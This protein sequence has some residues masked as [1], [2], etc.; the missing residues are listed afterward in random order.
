MENY[1]L[2]RDHETEK[3]DPVSNCSPVSMGPSGHHLTHHHE[4]IRTSTHIRLS[5][6]RH[7]KSI[8]YERI[9][10]KM[11]PSRVGLSD[12]VGEDDTIATSH[13]N[14][15][16]SL[17]TASW[18]WHTKTSK[19]PQDNV[20]IGHE[21]RSGRKAWKLLVSE[22]KIINLAAATVNFDV[23]AG[24]FGIDFLNNQRVSKR[25]DFCSE[26]KLSMPDLNIWIDLVFIEI[27]FR[28]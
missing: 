18:D 28:L 5:S 8:T 26:S 11:P 12:R 7:H 1:K 25:K 10:L 2:I 13:R 15:D 17:P 24:N 22:K 14:P 27:N 20:I 23:T 3:V 4:R 19:I 9:S 6:S 21:N 16:Y